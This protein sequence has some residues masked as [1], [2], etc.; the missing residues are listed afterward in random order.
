VDISI[1]K[2]LF[3]IE[4]PTYSA[5]LVGQCKIVLCWYW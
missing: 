2:R 4:I 5:T 3:C 1:Q